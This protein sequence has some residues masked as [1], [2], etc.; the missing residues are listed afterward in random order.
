VVFQL[1]HV[2]EGPTMPDASEV[3]ADAWAEHQ[4]R[5]TAN[6]GRGSFFCQFICGGL[7]YQ[8]EHHLFPRI[9]HVHYPQIAP[10][11]EQCAKEHGLPYHENSTFWGAVV[12]HGRTLK[13]LGTA[14]QRDRVVEQPLRAAA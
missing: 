9:C 8:V 12:S 5:T 6:F 10:I 13:A 7:N 1:A 11:V 2:V 4:M 14:P 3:A